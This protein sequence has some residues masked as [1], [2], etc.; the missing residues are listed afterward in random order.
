MSLTGV[1]SFG[2]YRKGIIRSY[3]ATL[4]GPDVIQQCI[5]RVK[6]RRGNYQGIGI[7]NGS[8]VYQCYADTGADLQLSRYGPAKTCG[9]D[10][11]GASASNTTAVFLFS[12]DCQEI[13]INNSFN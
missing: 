7:T 3:I 13:I 11:L 8:G 5:N 6:G 12:G 10:G 2:C 1:N 9:P 4:T